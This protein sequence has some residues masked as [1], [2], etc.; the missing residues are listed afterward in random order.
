MSPVILLVL[1]IVWK[2]IFPQVSIRSDFASL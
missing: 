1:N 2:K